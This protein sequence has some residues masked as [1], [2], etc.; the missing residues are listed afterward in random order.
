MHPGYVQTDMTDNYGNRTPQQGAE[1]ILRATLIVVEDCPFGQYF[2]E[3]KIDEFW[4]LYV[5][6]LHSNVLSHVYMFILY[7]FLALVLSNDRV[8]MHRKRECNKIDVSIVH[9]V[10][11]T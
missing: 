8:K 4:Y 2:N 1:Y 10:N 9:Q 6:T 5:E 7:A 3:D 11:A